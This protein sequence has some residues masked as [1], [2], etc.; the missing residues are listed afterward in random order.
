MKESFL[1]TKTKMSVGVLEGE[2]LKNKSKR[3]HIKPKGPEASAVIGRVH[4]LF[5][6]I[7][8]LKNTA[9]SIRH[10]HRQTECRGA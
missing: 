7:P 9:M 4:R 2:I 1:A 6:M 8:G 10:M 3:I 5:S